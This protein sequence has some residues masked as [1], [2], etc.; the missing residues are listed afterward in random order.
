MSTRVLHVIDHLG[1]GGGQMSVKNI[2]ENIDSEKFESLVCALRTNPTTIAIKAKVISLQYG[3][4]DPRSILAVIKL[5]KEH[6]ID[7]IHAHLQKSIIGCL[8]ASYFRRMPVIVH[9]RGAIFRRGIIARIYRVF[10]RMLH[11]RA[12]VIIANSQATARE[13]IK[14]VG[15]NRDRIKTIY[16][17]VDFASFDPNKISRS[18]ARKESEISGTDTI[19]GFVGRLHKVKGADLLIK[20]FALLLQQSPRYLL[21]LAGDG[22]ERKSLEAL[23]TRLGITGRVRFLGVCRNVP[24]LMSALDIGAVPSRQESFGIVALEFMRMK[25]PVVCSGVEGLAELVKNEVTGLVTKENTP[26]QIAAAIQHLADDKELQKKLIDNAYSFSKQFNVE[27]HVKKIEKIY[28]E[29]LCYRNTL[30]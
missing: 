5:C 29:L 6:K 12:A 14:R 1:L 26:K 7:I 17:P 30:K 28:L 4:W 3:K 18:Q 2:T 21:V 20:A 15:I 24:E 25:K 16:N 11:H 23:T 10:L 22:P 27:E 13:L 8:I 19:I 9:E